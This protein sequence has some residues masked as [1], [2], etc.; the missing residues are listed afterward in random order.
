ME[1]NRNNRRKG[2]GFTNISKYLAANDDNTLGSTIGTAI[3]KK[4]KEGEEEAASVSSGFQS[5][6]DKTRVGSQE[7]IDKRKG[8]LD[9]FDTTESTGFGGITEEEDGSGDVGTVSGFLSGDYKGPLD[10]ASK[11]KESLRAKTMALSNLA[12]GTR[13]AGGREAL[14]SRFIGDKN[15]TGGQQKL[16]SLLLGKTGTGALEQARRGATSSIGN[17]KQMSEGARARGDQYAT[18]TKNF[19]D[20]TRDAFEGIGSGIQDNVKGA[21]GERIGAL[22]DIRDSKRDYNVDNYRDIEDG[23]TAQE[24]LDAS[25]QKEQ[26]ALSQLGLGYDE[27]T[28]EGYKF[29]YGAEDPYVA[30]TRDSEGNI[31]FNRGDL[32]ASRSVE[33]GTKLEALNKLLGRE[34]VGSEYDTGNKTELDPNANSV[35]TLKEMLSGRKDQYGKDVTSQE[36]RIQESTK[37]Y[38]GFMDILEGRVMLPGAK[39][40]FNSLFIL[41]SQ[42]GLPSMNDYYKKHGGIGWAGAMV[43]DLVNIGKDKLSTVN[44]EKQSA[45]DI[46]SGYNVYGQDVQYDKDGFPIKGNNTVGDGTAGLQY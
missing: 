22:M 11:E 1:N 13:T 20:S 6:A 30:S 29:L 4:S 44:R 41:A 24:Q 35:D 12:G 28:G 14:L 19:A 31:D 8:I 9:K 42:S 37:D 16:D 38:N 15:Y 17:M 7:D 33:Q 18:E 27:E 25:I 3:G 36:G 45:V 5:E 2:T 26:D 46:N 23:L 32:Q 34:G 40:A 21:A 43:Q 10:I 39:S